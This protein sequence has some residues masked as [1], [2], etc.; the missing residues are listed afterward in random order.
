MNN[1]LIDKMHLGSL[2]GPGALAAIREYNEYYRNTSSALPF[3]LR[4]EKNE[5]RKPFRFK[6]VFFDTTSTTNRN[7]SH[8]SM[9]L[10]KFEYL[11]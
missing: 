9:K 6:K 8:C 11:H 7:S 3:Q 10:K 5:L 4:K 1:S 2:E